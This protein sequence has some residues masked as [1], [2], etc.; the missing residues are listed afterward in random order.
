MQLGHAQLSKRPNERLDALPSS[1]GMDFR[2]P[3][4]QP[5]QFH[6]GFAEGTV[7]VLGND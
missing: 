5:K 1:D 3:K 7:L 2:L 6:S 4:R